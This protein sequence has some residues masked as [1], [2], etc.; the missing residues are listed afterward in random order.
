MVWNTGCCVFHGFEV[1]H[2]TIEVCNAAIEV[3]NAAIEVWNTASEV[4]NTAR[5][6]SIPDLNGRVLDLRSSVPDL[7]GSILDLPGSVPNLTDSILDLKA[8]QYSGPQHGTVSDIEGGQ[9]RA[10]DSLFS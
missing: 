10:T 6:C 7:P 8:W 3:C 4:Q 5:Y 1:W 9:D 2:A